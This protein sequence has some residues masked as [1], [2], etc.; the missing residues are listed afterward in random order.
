M[1]RPHSDEVVKVTNVSEYLDAH[2]KYGFPTF[3]RGQAQDWPLL[4]SIARVSSKGWDSLLALEDALIT[5]LRRYGHPYFKSRAVGQ[6][7]WILH[8]QHFGLPTRLLDF[9]QNPL[10]ALYFAVEDTSLVE[11]GVVWS[12]DGFENETH[13]ELDTNVVEFL[14]P[15]HINERII[16]QESVFAHFALGETG[17]VPGMFSGAFCNPFPKIVIPGCD[18]K[19][20]REEL[21]I[22]GINKM[23]M[24]PGIDG[25]VEKIKEECIAGST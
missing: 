9:T 4:P 11:D 8:A 19:N 15:T 2:R 16:A 20:I 3:Y 17:D 6:L 1:A 12:V 7:D 13:D 21:D 25:V 18:K 10:K 24:Y 22:L 23:S 14:A 5:K